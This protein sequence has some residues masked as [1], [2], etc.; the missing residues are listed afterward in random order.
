M[1]RR[2]GAH[3]AIDDFGTGYSN[4]ISI[5][6]L[7]PD[8]IKICGELV[9]E[10]NH[11]PAVPLL[12]RGLS[13]LSK[14]MQIPL[15]AEHVSSPDIQQRI[16]HFGIDFSQGYYFGQPQSFAH[17]V[18]ALQTEKERVLCSTK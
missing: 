18:E 12:L 1:V 10:V 11:D 17:I 5:A 2:Y 6:Q 13:Q 7:R 14:E 9:R 16:A 4:L 15:I 3:I 8:Y